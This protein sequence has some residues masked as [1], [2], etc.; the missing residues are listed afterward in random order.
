MATPRFGFIQAHNGVWEI[1]KI[2]TG[3]WMLYADHEQA[4]AKK[5]LEIELAFFTIKESFGKIVA[6]EQE[7]QQI[8]EHEFQRGYQE[9]EEKYQQR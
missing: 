7:M 2:S 5:D 8:R 4:L 3:P 9:A 1:V 6:M